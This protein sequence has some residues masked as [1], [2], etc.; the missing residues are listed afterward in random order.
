MDTEGIKIALLGNSGVGKTCI[1]SRF[2]DNTFTKNTSSTIS[3][4]FV[5]KVITRG[6]DKYV[7]NIWDTAGQEKYQSLGRHFYKNAYIVLP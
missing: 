5:E 6:K 7:L 1:I 4:N 3:A 2:Y